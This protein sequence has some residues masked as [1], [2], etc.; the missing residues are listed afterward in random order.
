MEHSFDIFKLTPELS[1]GYAAAPSKPHRHDYEEIIL[2]TSGSPDHFIDF[3]REKLSAP[4]MIY[5]AQGKIHQFLPDKQTA[6]WVIRYKNEFIKESRFHFYANFLDNIN[7]PLP[8]GNCLERVNTLCEMMIEEYQ[9]PEP[10]FT[11]IKHLLA[12]LLAKLESEQKQRSPHLNVTTNTHLISFNNFLK[13]LEQNYKRPEGVQF[14][15]DKMNMSVRNLN[16][17]CQEIF[18]K[19]VSDIVEARKMIEARQLLIDTDLTVAEIGY[20]LGF[21]E[22]SYFTRVFSKRTG[23]T[24]TA[25]RSRM[26]VLFS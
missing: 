15:A 17:I 22:K 3:K 24:P 16:L 19:S 20:E 5:V 6:C 10:D 26:S 9:V 7:Y 23:L 8:H 1:I 13:I 11:M 14:Y 18:S 12:A 25:F 2:V 21:N 4:L